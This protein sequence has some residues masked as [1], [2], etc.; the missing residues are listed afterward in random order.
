M[1]RENQN[2]CGLLQSLL[3][4]LGQAYR[5]S[6]NSG[7]LEKSSLIRPSQGRAPASREEDVRVKKST[8]KKGKVD[9]PRSSHGPVIATL[10][11]Q[12]ESSWISS[13]LFQKGNEM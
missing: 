1:E 5:L 13:N 10:L 9:S 2:W 12:N 8:R 11:L 3:M 6:C 7:E 4:S